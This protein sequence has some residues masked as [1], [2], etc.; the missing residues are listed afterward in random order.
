MA[1]DWSLLMS[2]L[3]IDWRELACQNSALK[4]L[5]QDKDEEN[6]LRVL[7]MHVGCGYSLRETAVRA[8]QSG[9][10]TMS[11]VALLKRLRKSEGWLHALCCGLFEELAVC[12]DLHKIPERVR[13][14]DASSIKEPGQT[15]SIWRLHYS[16]SLPSL[17]CDFF[18]ITPCKGK[19]NGESL[20]RYDA[21]EGEHLVADR[22]YSTAQGVYSIVSQGAD[23]TVRLNPQNLR[24]FKLNGQPLNLPKV[25]GKIV[26]TRQCVDLAAQISDRNGMHC[27]AGR[28]CAVR[29]S[30]AAIAIAHKKL[31]QRAIRKGEELQEATLFYAQY[32]LVFTTVAADQSS[33]K[34]ILDL[35][36]LRWQIELVFKRFKQQ[37]E[38][39]HLPK[40]DPAS[41]RAWL[42][43]KLLTV[44]L[45]EKLIAHAERFS[46]WGYALQE[47]DL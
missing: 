33:A 41:S 1:E 30:K 23:V 18:E 4:G 3:P 2:F 31:H 14:I 15:G 35:Y 43:G 40:S 17:C 36:R 34:G 11:D 16:L 28:I 29:K 46:P 44:L 21:K 8:R 20:C 7:L 25:L 6:L 37:A 5:R 39:G 27:V 26:K 9:I 42:Y 38:L 12:S 32:I 22:G 24:I 10:A 45:T 13:L 19:G 47:Q